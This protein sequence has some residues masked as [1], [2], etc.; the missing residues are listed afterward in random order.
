MRLRRKAIKTSIK[1][2]HPFWVRNKNAGIIQISSSISM[3]K[4][5]GTRRRLQRSLESILQQVDANK[6]SLDDFDDHR[7]VTAITDSNPR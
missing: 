2:S 7:N 1:H 4:L 3:V 5:V 6:N